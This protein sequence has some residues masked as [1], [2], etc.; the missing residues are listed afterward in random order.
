MLVKRETYM[1]FI[2]L[3]L[4]HNSVFSSSIAPKILITVCKQ[5]Y[6]KIRIISRLVVSGSRAWR[7]ITLR[8]DISLKDPI[9]GNAD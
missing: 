8:K 7:F 9:D 2:W 3:L 1:D 6:K 5:S 4:K